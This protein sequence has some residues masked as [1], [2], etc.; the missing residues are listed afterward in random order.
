MGIRGSRTW[1]AAAAG[2]AAAGLAAVAL[3]GAGSPA[4]A[5]TQWDQRN[6]GVLG[7]YSHLTSNL[8][9][10]FTPT[11]GAVDTVQLCLAGFTFDT[12]GETSLAV[13]IVEQTE[14]GPVVLG[15]SAP[16]TLPAT[17]SPLSITYSTVQFGFDQPIALRPGGSYSIDGVEI[18]SYAFAAETMDPANP[19]GTGGV[20]FREGMTG[21]PGLDNATSFVAAP[22]CG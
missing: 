17:S 1:R 5:L 7:S 18:E 21:T 19:V 14:A 9:V 10:P 20:W 22:T 11:L 3:A 4:Q 13:S 6:D 15:T 2:V 8:S 16:A 12:I